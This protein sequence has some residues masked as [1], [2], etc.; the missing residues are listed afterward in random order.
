L[1][2]LSIRRGS[3]LATAME[4]R[5]FGASTRRTWARPSRF[6][7]PEIV[8][9]VIGCAVAAAA[10]TAAILAGTWRFLGGQ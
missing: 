8:L 10:I 7:R 4:A 5:G 9:L 1:L 3:K 6:G 2:V